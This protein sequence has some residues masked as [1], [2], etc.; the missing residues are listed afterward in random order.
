[1]TSE[2][3]APRDGNRRPKPSPNTTIA[4]K[5]GAAAPLET[6]RIR[7]LAQRS[8]NPNDTANLREKSSITLCAGLAITAAAISENVAKAI[9]EIRGAAPATSSAIGR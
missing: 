7:P 1:M 3:V 6:P 9:P 5:A 8:V 4:P 2:T